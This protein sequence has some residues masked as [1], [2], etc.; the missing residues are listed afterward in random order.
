MTEHDAILTDLAPS[1]SEAELIKGGAPLVIDLSPL[2]KV[3]LDLSGL[4]YSP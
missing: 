1:E 4:I 3:T 2:A